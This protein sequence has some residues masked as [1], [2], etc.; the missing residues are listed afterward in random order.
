MKEKGVFP[1]SRKR[2]KKALKRDFQKKSLF[3]EAFFRRAKAEGKKMENQK[4]CKN[5]K[6]YQADICHVPF[7]VEGQF[8]D[9]RITEAE[10]NCD[11]FEE[12][13][14]LMTKDEQ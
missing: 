4:K 12:S 5:C 6:F 1:F 10:K 2:R 8:Y 9:G 11:L 13:D 14:T 3:N 7:W